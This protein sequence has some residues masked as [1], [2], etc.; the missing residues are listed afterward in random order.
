[1]TWQRCQYVLELVQQTVDCNCF[2]RLISFDPVRFRLL[3]FTFRHPGRLYLS[4]THR[5]T[6]FSISLPVSDS[7]QVEPSTASTQAPHT[8][9]HPRAPPASPTSL[10]SSSSSSNS[11]RLFL[12]SL[13]PT[14]ALVFFLALNSLTSVISP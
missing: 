8:M 14:S 12:G 5:P 1:M 6:T 9:T 3:A 2:C 10:Q 13:F 11:T 7:A 4:L